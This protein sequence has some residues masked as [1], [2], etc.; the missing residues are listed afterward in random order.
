MKAA[1]I[2]KTWRI[3]LVIN[4]SPR[5]RRGDMGRGGA[6]LGKGDGGFR[7]II[8]KKKIILFDV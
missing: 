2:K 3:P 7:K 1:A 6:P 5:L 4:Y 8:L